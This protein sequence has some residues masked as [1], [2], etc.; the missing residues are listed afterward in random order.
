[1]TGS[2]T[3]SD[4]HL[5]L[6]LGVTGVGKSRLVEEFV[7]TLGDRPRVLRGR[8]LP[9]G[10]GIAYRRSRRSS[11]RPPRSA[12]TTI[13]SPPSR[14]SPTSSAATQGITNRLARLLDLPGSI[15]DPKDAYRALRRLLE[16]AAEDRPLVL[17]IDDLHCAQP[18]LLDF[19]ED[20]AESL[21]GVPVLLLG[22]ARFGV[23]R[24]PPQLD[25]PMP[26]T[27]SRSTCDRCVRQ[28]S[29]QPRAQPSGRGELK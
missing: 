20:A 28:P 23:L 24:G 13:P 19:I 1:M 6:V 8:C 11:A 3:K 21:G 10:D 16:F 27:P 5:V 22:M 26:A 7:R 14:S 2:S 25:A 12:R 29:G 15:G 18:V 17:V 9:Y 4:C